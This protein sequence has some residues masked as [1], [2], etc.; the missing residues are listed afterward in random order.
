[1]PS[2]LLRLHGGSLSLFL[3]DCRSSCP[4][5]KG[6][7]LKCIDCGK[8]T[9]VNRIVG[10]VNSALGRWPWQ[11]SLHFQG[12]HAC[13]GSL[14]AP[15]W[16]V[17]AAH[18]VSQKNYNQASN[19]VVYAGFLNQNQMASAQKSAVQLIY[20]N[21]NYDASTQDFDIALMKLASPVTFTSNVKAVCLPTAGTDFAAGTLCWISGWGLMVEEGDV[22]NTMQEAQIPLIGLSTCNARA[23]YAG[24]LTQR[25]QCAGYAAGGVDACQGDSGGPLVCTSRDGLWRLTGATSWGIGCAVVNKPG[26]YSKI[27]EYLSWITWTM[28]YDL[29]NS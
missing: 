23:M 28:A 2:S 14:V 13:G 29:K 16:L 24:R 10:G 27:P 8:S 7:S 21:K 5:G 3:F 11:V 17:T 12:S 25:M 9:V 6:I 4:S 18:C 19:W 1:C 15:G 26:I 22:A 20:V